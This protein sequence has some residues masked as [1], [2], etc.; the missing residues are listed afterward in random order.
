MGYRTEYG[1]LRMCGG[2]E[3]RRGGKGRGGGLIGWSEC[4][5]RND[6][7]KLPEWEY[8]EVLK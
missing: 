2:E 6:I 7:V 5:A 1:Y 8:D 3:G 4:T